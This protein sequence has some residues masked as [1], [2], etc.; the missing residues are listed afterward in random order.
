MGDYVAGPSHTLPPGGAGRA[1]AGLRVEDVVK[2]VSVG[3][4][5]KGAVRRSAAATGILARLERLD[6][7]ADSVETRIS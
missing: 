2:R 4:Y 1:F 3:E 6:A 7:H 5:G